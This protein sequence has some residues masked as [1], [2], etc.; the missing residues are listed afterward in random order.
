M[1]EIKERARGCTHETRKNRTN[2]HAQSL[3]QRVLN[4]KASLHPVLF[5]ID[6][7]PGWTPRQDHG[8]TEGGL[9]PFHD[10]R[11]AGSFKIN[12]DSGAYR[13]FSCGAAGGDIIAYYRLRYCVDFM[14]ALADLEGRAGI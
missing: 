10:D 14:T 9:C 6:E 13:C 11:R 2:L 12:L 4:L 5:Y 3:P 8:W 7:F 1:S